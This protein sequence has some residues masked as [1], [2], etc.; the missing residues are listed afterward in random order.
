VSRG[1]RPARRPLG[2]GTGSVSNRGD[3]AVA[4]TR[5]SSRD[6]SLPQKSRIN[7]QSS[8]RNPTARESAR[9]S[10]GTRQRPKG[11]PA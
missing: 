11:G 4:D 2:S 9:L 1:L 3:S 7:T 8:D 6:R 10:C 5:A